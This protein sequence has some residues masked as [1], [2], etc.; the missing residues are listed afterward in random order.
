MAVSFLVFSADVNESLLKRIIKRC[1][2]DPDGE[3]SLP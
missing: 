3:G 2:R 1:F